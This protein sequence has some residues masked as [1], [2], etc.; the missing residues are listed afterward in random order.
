MERI[1]LFHIFCIVFHLVCWVATGPRLLLIAN[2][3]YLFYYFLSSPLFISLSI[4]PVIMNDALVIFYERKIKFII[5]K[6]EHL[7]RWTFCR[8][9]RSQ[10]KILGEQNC[11]PGKAKCFYIMYIENFVRRIFSFENLHTY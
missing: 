10:R 8:Q 4:L 7:H 3:S 5:R 2:N 9:G 6:N 11:R 1:L